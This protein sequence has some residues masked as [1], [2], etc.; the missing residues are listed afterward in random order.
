MYAGIFQKPRALQVLDV[1]SAYIMCLTPAQS[2]L[3]AI[4]YDCCHVIPQKGKAAYAAP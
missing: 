4:E 1:L 3:Q 2:A